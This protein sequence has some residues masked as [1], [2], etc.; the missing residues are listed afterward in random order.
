MPLV[1]PDLKVKSL[2]AQVVI[3]E[4]CRYQSYEHA[5]TDLK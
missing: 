5:K 2:Y 4:V 1:V 3:D